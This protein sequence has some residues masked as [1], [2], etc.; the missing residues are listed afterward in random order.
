[1]KKKIELLT[2]DE[3]DL[4]DELRLE[5]NLKELRATARRKALG[6]TVQLEPDVAQYF[7]DNTAVNE[8]LRTLI[9][10]S[11]EGALAR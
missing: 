7:P 2:D 10:L 8:A 1:M 9:R 3:F 11:K 4:N 5:Y 6:V